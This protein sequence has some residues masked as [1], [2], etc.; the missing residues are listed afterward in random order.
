MDNNYSDEHQRKGKTDYEFLKDRI[1]N[2]FT[3]ISTYFELKGMLQDKKLS[4]D[5]KEFIEKKL[6]ELEE[7][8]QI[9][10]DKILKLV[11]GD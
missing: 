4:K 7:Q 2:Y 10:V 6:G 3:P 9:E 11:E 1:R 5:K 8:C